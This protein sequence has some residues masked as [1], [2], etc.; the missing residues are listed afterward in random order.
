MSQIV[1][2]SSLWLW[3]YLFYLLSICLYGIVTMRLE[4]LKQHDRIRPKLTRG[5]ELKLAVFELGTVPLRFKLHLYLWVIADEL[6]LHQQFKQD[7]K[8]FKLETSFCFQVS[9]RSKGDFGLT[10]RGKSYLDDISPFLHIL[11]NKSETFC[12]IWQQNFMICNTVVLYC[13]DEFT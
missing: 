13:F 1:I 8:Y 6:D 9:L 10:I 3:V 12:N 2:N 4:F 7:Y 11:F 5:G